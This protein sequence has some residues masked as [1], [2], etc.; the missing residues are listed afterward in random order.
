[1][2]KLEPNFDDDQFDNE[3]FSDFHSSAFKNNWHQKDAYFELEQNMETT[4]AVSFQ[5]LCLE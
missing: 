1:M 2:A 5:A 3:H 4:C